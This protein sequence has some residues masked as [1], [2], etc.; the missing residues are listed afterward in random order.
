[1]ITTILKKFNI[2]NIILLGQPPKEILEE[3]LNNETEITAINHSNLKNINTIIGHPLICLPKL[4][5]YD[6]IFINDDANWYTLYNEL[7]IIKKTNE[8]FP[9]VFVCNN[10][11][12]F[13]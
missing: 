7:N 5:N 13:Y 3:I 4:E 8:N 11:F 9:L 6:A 10:K 2:K 1:M 12:C